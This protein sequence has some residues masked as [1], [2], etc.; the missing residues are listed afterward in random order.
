MRL[1]AAGRLQL[2]VRPIMEIFI[3]VVSPDKTVVKNVYAIPRI[4]DHI[5]PVSDEKNILA[6]NNVIW[7][8]N[9][10][11]LENHNAQWCGNDVKDMQIEAIIYAA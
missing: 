9:R 7:W 4:N 2:T 6:V 1:A 8:P 3:L 10:Q 11:E 5:F